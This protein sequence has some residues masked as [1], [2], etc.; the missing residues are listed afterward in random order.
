[1]RASCGC[2]D[3]DPPVTRLAYDPVAAVHGLV[4]LAPVTALLGIVVNR[5]SEG[6]QPLARCPGDRPDSREHRRGLSGAQ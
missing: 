2:R 4:L 1:M 6:K 3:E 5:D